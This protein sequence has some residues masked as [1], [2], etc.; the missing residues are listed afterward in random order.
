MPCCSSNQQ[1]FL[2][3]SVTLLLNTYYLIHYNHIYKLHTNVHA[4]LFYTQDHASAPDV[5]ED[6]RLAQLPQ[7]PRLV[8]EEMA[9]AFRDTSQAFT[10]NS[11]CLR[12]LGPLSK[13]GDCDVTILGRSETS[14]ILG[15]PTW[16]MREVQMFFAY[17]RTMERKHN[18][19]VSSNDHPDNNGSVLRTP[20]WDRWFGL[21]GVRY[22]R[23][24]RNLGPRC[25]TLREKLRRRVVCD[26]KHNEWMEWCQ[27]VRR[28]AFLGRRGMGRRTTAPH[29]TANRRVSITPTIDHGLIDEASLKDPADDS[30]DEETEIP[31][32]S[33]GAEDPEESDCDS[34]V[35]PASVDVAVPD[36]PVSL[37]SIGGRSNPISLVEEDPCNHINLIDMINRPC[38]TMAVK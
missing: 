4:L 8:T 3:Y 30:S 21:E 37:E 15:V 25:Y 14:E 27:D 29:H 22:R 6:R 7:F 38:Q 19:R 24:V 13:C 33:S 2:I 36:K 31:D 28:R 16:A 20:S 23:D 17:R 9:E 12:C 10:S 11:I 35:E 1:T 5:H 32:L 26:Q 34:D 18:L